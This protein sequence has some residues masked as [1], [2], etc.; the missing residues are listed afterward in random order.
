MCLASRERARRADNFRNLCVLEDGHAVRSQPFAQR[1]LRLNHPGKVFDE[2]HVLRAGV[3]DVFDGRRREVR[4]GAQ[5]VAQ[6][7]PD[8]LVRLLLSL[9]HSPNILLHRFD[10]ASQVS[11]GVL[12]GILLIG[13][14]LGRLR[15]EE[16]RPDALRARGLH[17]HRNRNELKRQ[18]LLLQAAL[19]H[20]KGLEDGGVKW[21]VYVND[22]VDR[23]GKL[24]GVELLD[25][26][27]AADDPFPRGEPSHD[28]V[29][30]VHLLVQ[31]QHRPVEVDI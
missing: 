26:R 31:L 28:R 23:V 4:N 25:Q 14:P 8:G 22:Q 15:L 13:E 7:P 27:V 9:V 11:D 16:V 24:V 6:I 30:R 5:G 18:R 3:N 21:K 19:L 20:R 1:E 29:P 17:L 12:D 10:H 2:G